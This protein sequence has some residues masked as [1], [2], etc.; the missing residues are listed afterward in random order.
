MIINVEGDTITAKDKPKRKF[1]RIKRKPEYLYDYMC[2]Q[3]LDHHS[4]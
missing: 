4:N 1:T 3:I 2:E